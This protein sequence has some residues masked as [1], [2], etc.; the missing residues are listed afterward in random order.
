MRAQRDAQR[1]G[2]AHLNRNPKVIDVCRDVV[3]FRH[4]ADWFTRHAHQ[5]SVARLKFRV[6]AA[7]A[8]S[9]WQIGGPVWPGSGICRADRPDTS[10]SIFAVI[11]RLAERAEGPRNCN[12]GSLAPRHRE[13]M[14]DQ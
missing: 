3:D 9:V 10:G 14:S 6:L 5:L 7:L 4:E 1:P 12:P 8:A 2:F 11:P 13:T